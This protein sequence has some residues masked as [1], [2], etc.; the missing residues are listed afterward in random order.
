MGVCS[1]TP[2]QDLRGLPKSVSRDVTV[3]AGR[4]RADDPSLLPRFRAPVNFLGLGQRWRRPLGPVMTSGGF[5]GAL[6]RRLHDFLWTRIDGRHPHRHP[7]GP[8]PAVPHRRPRRVGASPSSKT[9]SSG[10]PD[11]SIGKCRGR[12]VGFAPISFMTRDAFRLR[13]RPCRRLAAMTPEALHLVLLARHRDIRRDA[14]V[15]AGERIPGML[16]APPLPRRL[17]VADAARHRSCVLVGRMLRARKLRGVAGR[18]P[19]G[20]LAIGMRPRSLRALAGGEGQQH[21]EKTR[22][23]LHGTSS[24]VVGRSARAFGRVRAVRRRRHPPPRLRAPSRSR[25][26]WPSNRDARDASWCGGP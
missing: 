12:E 18:A 2:S 25:P 7:L 22:T 16:D 5:G 4:R 8:R 11:R 21:E 1:P 17:G 26:A 10:S 24:R 3:L 20:I 23:A 19:R 14:R 13:V 9:P 15:R 6:R